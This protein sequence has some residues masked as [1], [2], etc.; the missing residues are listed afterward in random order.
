MK[1][2]AC[3]AHD[4]L[5][6]ARPPRV[7]PWSQ[8]RWNRH[9]AG[10]WRMPNWT[11]R[12]RCPPAQPI[13]QCFAATLGPADPP[14]PAPL[15]CVCGGATI[16][17]EF[18]LPRAPYEDITTRFGP[19][20]IAGTPVLASL[21]STSSTRCP[22]AWPSQHGLHGPRRAHLDRVHTARAE[23]NSCSHL[24]VGAG[25]IPALPRGCQSLTAAPGYWSCRT[26]QRRHG[27]GRRSV[28]QYPALAFRDR[29]G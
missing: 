24:V 18:S 29:K 20:G 13:F 26:F 6:T 16:H 10:D 12:Q 19:Y 8:I 15:G 9:P 1:P 25:Q 17:P 27:R 4:V 22:H 5:F 21:C 14:P 7:L 28:Q 3:M 23:P 11:S 2:T